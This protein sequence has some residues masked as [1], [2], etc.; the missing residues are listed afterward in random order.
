MKIT[1]LDGFAVNPGDLDWGILE[2]YGTVTVYDRTDSDAESIERIGDSEVVL[3]NKTP[4]PASVIEACP[5]DRH[6]GHWL[7]YC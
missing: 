7:Q 1:I 6:A 5:Y 2:S 3:V 4:L